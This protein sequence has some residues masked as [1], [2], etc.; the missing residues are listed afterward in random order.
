[1]IMRIKV[2]RLSKQ[3][4]VTA[5]CGCMLLAFGSGTLS[6][7]AD[8]A[9]L[10]RE[11]DV[12]RTAL[13]KAAADATAGRIRP[14]RSSL[15]SAQE[16]WSRFYVGYRAWG[17]A[18]DPA[19][20]TDIDAIQAEF[21][22]ATNAVTPGNNAPLAA[23]SLQRIQTLLAGLLQR[24]EVPDIDAAVKELSAALSEVQTSMK[25]M[26]GKA[27]GPESLA[28]LSEQWGDISESWAAFN[29]VLID[30]NPLNLSERELATLKQRTDRQSALFTTVGQALGNANLSSGLTSL[31]S[32][33]EG[34]RALATQWSPKPGAEDATQKQP[35]LDPK[36]KRRLNF[37]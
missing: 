16:S 2:R 33:V 17:T 30:A 13:D 35:L 34:L 8:I 15:K 31:S 20:T 24:N 29:K 12:V 28:A 11:V 19:W 3:T 4:R 36:P 7:A 21:M 26:E 37:R 25:A 32:A 18:T 14:L 23:T 5:F 10:T 22:N 9:D 6:A 27:L 1:M